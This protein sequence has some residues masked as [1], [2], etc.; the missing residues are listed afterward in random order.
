LKDLTFAVRQRLVAIDNARFAG[1]LLDV[2]VEHQACDCRAEERFSLRH[3][4]DS[5][6]EIDVGGILQQ[7][8]RRAR[9]QDLRHVRFIGMHAQH[10]DAYAGDVLD[11]LACGFDAIEERHRDVEYGHIG[12]ELFGLAD[13]FAAVACLGD[14][15][16]VRALLEHL[17]QTLAYDRVIVG[18]QNANGCHSLTLHGGSIE[19][20]HH[21]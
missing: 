6:N 16:P 13:G 7:V 12:F 14:D 3:G 11:D 17:P 10:E 4:G 20:Q 2:V 15:L 19:C 21:Q 18:E 8:S 9:L 5:L 1:A